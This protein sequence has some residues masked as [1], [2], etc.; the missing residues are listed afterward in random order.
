MCSIKR[1]GVSAEGAWLRIKKNTLTIIKLLRN[2]KKHLSFVFGL[3]GVVDFLAKVGLHSLVDL[4]DLI[5]SEFDSSYDSGKLV[6][7]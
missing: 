1:R 4:V 2:L 6:D 3:I 7:L 5:G